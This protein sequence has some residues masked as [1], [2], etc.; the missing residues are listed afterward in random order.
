M[1]WAFQPILPAAAELLATEPPA[2][3]GYIKVWTG[4]EWT[5]KPVKV[6]NGTD[7][8]IKPLKR[9]TGTTWAETS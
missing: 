2:I 6:W 5:K 8:V 9:W 1:S 3:T 4:S 7:W